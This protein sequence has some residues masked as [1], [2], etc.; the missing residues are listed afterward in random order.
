MESPSLAASRSSTAVSQL[1]SASSCLPMPLRMVHCLSWMCRFSILAGPR[2]IVHVGLR[3]SPETT[4]SP[5]QI[6]DQKI[7]C[8]TRIVVGIVLVVGEIMGSVGGCHAIMDNMEFA[9]VAL[10]VAF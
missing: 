7:S 2:G 10:L 8:A 1:R 9:S 5:R 4:H 6:H 3:F